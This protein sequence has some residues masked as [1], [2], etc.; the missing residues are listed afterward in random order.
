[1]IFNASATIKGL[2]LGGTGPAKLSIIGGTLFSDDPYIQTNG[3][4]NLAGD[5]IATGSM[6]VHGT[7]QWTNG[8]LHMPGNLAV[9]GPVGFIYP[10]GSLITYSSDSHVFGGTC[11]NY[12]TISCFSTNLTAISGSIINNSN[13]VVIATN[14]TLAVTG[15]G[16]RSGSVILNSQINFTST[17]IVRADSGATLE[18]HSDLAMTD[19]QS[20]SVFNG[21]GVIRFASGQFICEGNCVLGQ[22]MGGPGGGGT[23]NNQGTLSVP[24]NFGPISLLADANFYN[25][26]TVTVGSGSGLNLQANLGT[27]NFQTGSVFDGAGVIRFGSGQTRRQRIST[28][29]FIAP[30]SASRPADTYDRRQPKRI[31]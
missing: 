22:G 12:G 23:F 18:M 6:S 26:G 11:Y 27:I 16:S 30:E 1:V 20:G 14:V 9:P 21:A 5:L 28:I 19:F 8:T 17:G 10:D 7:I 31:I 13:L 15:A 4:L 3:Q 29:G 2:N 25:Q 24:T